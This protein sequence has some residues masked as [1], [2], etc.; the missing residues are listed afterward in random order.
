[1][2]E[3]SSGH[4]HSLYGLILAANRTIA[5]VA[6]APS[7]STPDMRVRF[8]RVP[9]PSALRQD[10]RLLE[11]S[12]NTAEGRPLFTLYRRGDG[13]LFEF[14]DET[15]FVISGDGKDV[16]VSWQRP[17]GEDVAAAY[18][19]N[20]VMAFVL[21]L[22]GREVL[23]ASAVAV[24]GFAVA[25]AG[26]SGAGK[27][28]LAACL[29]RRGLVVLSEDVAALTEVDERF[30]VLPS[31]SRIRLWSD[32]A[33]LV[34][35]EELPFLDG[36]DWKRYFD[37]GVVPQRPFELAAIYSLDDRQTSPLAPRIEPLSARDGLVDL[38]AN[39]YHN[40]RDPQLAPASFERLGRLV[41]RVPLRLAVP[42]T[43]LASAFR[44]AELIVEDARRLL[45]A[46]SATVAS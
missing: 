9:D 7:P 27:S 23:H 35:D 28:T 44:L 4:L 34:S 29:A 43:D 17:A 21:R 45:A 15:Q 33:A 13:Y 25:V 1:M 38:I 12:P 39:T 2:P 46:R 16:L 36:T 6:S 14:P 41:R 8:D 3:H 10:T 24:D 26:P 31:H 37:V 18:L 19:V 5:G 22:H 40:V 42:H 32:S 30:F 20:T 11:H